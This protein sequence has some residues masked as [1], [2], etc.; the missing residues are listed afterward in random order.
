[1]LKSLIAIRIRALFGASKKT[2]QGTG[3]KIGR[4]IGLAFLF[5]YLGAAFAFLSVGMAISTAPATIAL[6]VEW[7]FFA[8][9]NVAAFSLIFIFSIFET[10][11]ELFECRDNELLLSMPIRERDIVLSR[12][13]TVLIINYI[14]C[15]VILLPAIIVFVA[16]G[17][18]IVALFG[19]LLVGL[20]IPPLATALASFV[21]YAVAALARRFKR[22]N[23]I[24][25]I[26]SLIFFVLYFVVY[27]AL[28]NGLEG[29]E[30]N[31][32]GAVLGMADTLSPIRIIG[33]ASLLR[34]LSTLIV[35]AVAVVI[36]VLSFIVI[37]NRYFAII[38][39]SH[40]AARTK[41]RAQ[42]LAGSSAFIA[43]AKKELRTFFSS[44]AYIM[45]GGIGALMQLALSVF[46]LVGAEDFRTVVYML[47]PVFDVLP[48]DLLLAASVA[49][50]MLLSLTTSVSA[51]ALS[52]ERR[53]LWII[54]TAPVRTIDIIHA[55]LVPHLLLAVPTGLIS[56]I[57]FAIAIR[58]DALSVLLLLLAPT[59]ANTVMALF[60]LIINIAM[61][62]FD[63]ENE[64]QIVKQSGA[65][66]IVVLGGMLGGIALAALGI[67]LSVLLGLIGICLFI[68]FFL[69]L[70][71]VL[72][73]ILTGASLKKLER[74][75]I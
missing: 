64:A 8:I 28:M 70:S 63:F 59:L 18:S 35:C 16:V 38:T 49:I 60:G 30:E 31:I 33:E 61:P 13:F 41:Y 47:S 62:R 3:R 6:G 21:G 44:A 56:A 43:L 14:E 27:S 20:V 72:Y 2:G 50:L 19:G 54:K 45:N 34:P 66:S 69:V 40:S 57:L 17:G 25:V 39:S 48:E 75:N 4:T 5:L 26:F 58:A 32:D 10:K 1:M 46:I 52:M 15:A 71:V 67:Y 29:L 7:L 11:S 23:L 42:R 51:S 68:L 24:T 22:K 9:F 12:I 73:F 53:A 36:S 74:I 37:K 55:K 65:A